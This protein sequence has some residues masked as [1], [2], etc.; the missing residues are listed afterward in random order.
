VLEAARLLLG[1]SL[2]KPEAMGGRCRIIDS[3]ARADA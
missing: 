3:R 1:S 2:F